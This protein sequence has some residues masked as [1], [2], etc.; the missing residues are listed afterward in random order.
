[1]TCG[2]VLFGVCGCGKTTLGQ[3]LAKRLR[4]VFIDADDFHPMNN[5]ERL[6]KG[7]ALTDADREPWLRTV[8]DKLRTQFR[9]ERS[10]VLACSA[11]R[12]CYRE[13]LQG[14]P[15]LPLHW[16]YLHAS[17][18][19]LAER[20]AHRQH[21]FMSP[22]LLDSQ[23]ATLEVIHP[24]RSYVTVSVEG[25]FAECMERLL[26]NLLPPAEEKSMQCRTL[27]AARS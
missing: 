11:L 27:S 9:E 7:L 8:H 2:V 18:E 25:N 12:R 20:L 21:A 13:I 14:N 3:A 17:R 26:G 22:A 23:L 10:F 15:P 5:R 4:W 6:Q 16:V 24:P 1:M 19:I